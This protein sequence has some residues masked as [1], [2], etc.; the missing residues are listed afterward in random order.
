VP[1]LGPETRSERR[2]A[3]IAA[4]WRCAAARS[5]RDL[6]VDDVCAEA[7][8]SKGAFYGYFAQKRDVLLALLEDDASALDREL[9]RITRC[10]PSIV[11]RLSW[12]MQATL[13]VGNDPARVQVRAELWA[14]LLTEDDVRRALAGATQRRRDRVQSWIEEAVASGELTGIPSSALASVLLALAD[15]LTLHNAL[16]SDVSAWRNLRRTIDMVLAGIAADGT[17]NAPVPDSCTHV[18]D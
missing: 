11:G 4:A 9:A 18:L 15:G 7:G 6:T 1:K 12:L 8:V 10:A 16:D 17:T 3:L 13:A 5:I 2:G 14:A